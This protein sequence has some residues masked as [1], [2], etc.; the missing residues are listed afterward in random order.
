MVVNGGSA[1]GL[2]EAETNRSDRLSCKG[3]SLRAGTCPVAVTVRNPLASALTPRV[4]HGLRAL[5]I[6]PPGWVSRTVYAPSERRGLRVLLR[7]GLPCVAHHGGRFETDCRNS[8]GSTWRASPEERHGGAASAGAPTFGV[9]DLAALTSG[10]LAVAQRPVVLLPRRRAFLATV[11]L[12]SAAVSGTTLA[13]R[14][15]LL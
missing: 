1:L 14:P 4:R 11:L 2:R 5:M 3:L 9:F 13:V 10:A 12:D 8:T 6:T 15:S 7:R